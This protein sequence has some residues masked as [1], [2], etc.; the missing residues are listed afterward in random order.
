V[1]GTTRGVKERVDIRWDDTDTGAGV[2]EVMMAAAIEL[3]EAGGLWWWSFRDGD[4]EIPGNHPQK[5]REDATEAA[6]TAYPDVAIHVRGQPHVRTG[7][8]ASLVACVLMC[9]AI[10]RHYRPGRG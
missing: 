2:P 3:W 4:L 6:R 9:L 1:G 10:W 7:G 5:S 8:R